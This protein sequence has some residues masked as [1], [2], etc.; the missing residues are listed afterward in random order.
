MSS[1]LIARQ[2]LF[3]SHRCFTTSPLNFG[4]DL[5]KAKPFK[6]I[7]NLSAFTMISR[8]FPG[9]KYY[10]ISMKDLHASI[11]KEFGEIVRFPPMLGRP[12]AVITYKAEDFEK[13]KLSEHEL[14]CLS[15]QFNI[16]YFFLRCVGL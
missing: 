8:S 1:K 15:S 12:G 6:D 7:P 13:V 11:R 5:E 2:L 9:G 14:M 3:N 10:K 16:V 4:N